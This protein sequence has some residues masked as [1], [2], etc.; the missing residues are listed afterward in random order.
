MNL[1][2]QL[3]PSCRLTCAGSQLGVSRASNT[4]HHVLVLRL[5][6]HPHVISRSIEILVFEDVDN[7]LKRIFALIIA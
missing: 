2:L 5:D 4:A 7:L 1:C 6:H 3:P